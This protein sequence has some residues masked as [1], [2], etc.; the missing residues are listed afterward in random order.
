MG[1]TVSPTNGVGETGRLHVENETGPLA[2][3][4]HENELT[5]DERLECKT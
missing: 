4:T 2:F 5:M 1:K 3:T